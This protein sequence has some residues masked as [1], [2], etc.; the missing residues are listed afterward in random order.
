MCSSAANS[1]AGGKL[2]GVSCAMTKR[3]MAEL[4]RGVAREPKDFARRAR[5]VTKGWQPTRAEISRLAT[6]A[7]GLAHAPRKAKARV[8]Y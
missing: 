7:A 4:A 6:E 1:L 2:A 5:T 8:G 3:E